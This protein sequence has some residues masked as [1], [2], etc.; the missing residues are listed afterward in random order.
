VAY[1]DDKRRK[2]LAA[3]EATAEKMESGSKADR[4]AAKGYAGRADDLIDAIAEKRIKLEDVKDE[5]LPEE[6]RKMTLEQ[7]RAHVEQKAKERA[8]LRAR[9]VELSKKR[10]EYLRQELEKR[11]AKDGFDA[12]VKEA[13]R[14]QAERKGIRI[15]K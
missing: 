6:M 10:D 9:I 15:E 13:L 7:R 14:K 12:V 3:H 4:A 2:E 1:G 8:E 11:G 5:H